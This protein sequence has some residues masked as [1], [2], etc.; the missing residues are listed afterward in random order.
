M[1]PAIAG[2]AT[3]TMNNVI[4]IC[5]R[6]RGCFAL[7][8]AHADRLGPA[9]YNLEL[10]RRRARSVAAFLRGGGIRS[11]I[12]QSAGET[13]LINKT[14]DGVR[15]AQNRRAEIWFPPGLKW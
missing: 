5:G 1:L 6:T 13:R 4:S 10:S 8:A 9:A 3:K 14:P 12:V 11:K 7:I 15:D 2:H